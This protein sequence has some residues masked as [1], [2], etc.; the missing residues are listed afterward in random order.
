M[1]V[2]LLERVRNLGQ[3]GDKVIVKAGYGRNCLIPTG[4][5]VMASKQNIEKFEVRR[6]EL[7]AKAAEKVSLAEKRAL[8]IA[9]MGPLTIAV[10]AGDEGKLFGSVVASDIVTAMADAGVEVDKHEIN[11]P[12]GH[13]R[14]VGEYT[15]RVQLHTD[16]NQ[17]VTVNVI[18][19]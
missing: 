4:R 5:A 7:E 10:R 19:E 13:M 2:I 17:D 1:E 3:L 6:A 9:E 18:P 14:H 12:G 11:L 8:K 16:V 15:V